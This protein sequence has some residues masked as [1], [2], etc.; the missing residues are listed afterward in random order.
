MSHEYLAIKKTEWL[1]APPHCLVAVG[2]RFFPGCGPVEFHW[3]SSELHRAYVRTMMSTASTASA[4]DFWSCI[5]LTFLST[6]SVAYFWS[7][8]MLTYVRLFLELHYHY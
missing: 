3:M 6:V 4:A 5:M 1:V 8:I 2:G 7:C